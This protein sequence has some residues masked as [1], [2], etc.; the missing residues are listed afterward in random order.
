VSEIAFIFHAFNGDFNCGHVDPHYLCLLLRY[1]ILS[2]K[3]EE[4]KSL[5]CTTTEDKPGVILNMSEKK[6]V[7]RRVF[8]GLEIVCIILIACLVGATSLYSWQINDKDDT[9]SSLNSKVSDLTDTLNLGKS[10]ILVNSQTVS[11]TADN[12]TSW[13]FNYEF[14]NEI[15]YLFSVPKPSNWSIKYAGI[16]SVDVYSSTN[17]TYVRATYDTSATTTY[18]NQTDVSTRGEAFFPVLPTSDIEIRV[19]NTNT[20]ENATE[21]VTITYYY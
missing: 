11:Q 12:Y 8:I 1:F 16:V 13:V 14:P 5:I 20:N 9:I 15:G 18:D 19:G 2:L 10:A 3:A 7:S 17:E 6:A 21:T 4:E